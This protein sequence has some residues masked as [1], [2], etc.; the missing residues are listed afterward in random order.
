MRSLENHLWHKLG[1]ARLRYSTKKSKVALGVNFTKEQFLNWLKNNYDGSCYYCR[2][3]L[4]EYQNKKI[5]K[6]IKIKGERFGIDRKNNQKGYFLDNIAV[7]CQICNSVKSFVFD[8]EEFKE[9]AK[10]YIRKL[11]G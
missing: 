3:S 6:K 5:Y 2:I 10:K 1:H 8:P 9:I 11:Y 4:E 7:S